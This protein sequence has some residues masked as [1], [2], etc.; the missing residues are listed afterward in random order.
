VPTPRLIPTFATAVNTWQC[1]E[2][3]HLNVQFYT[4]FGHEAS[5]HLLHRLGLGP[6]AR[7]AAGLSIRAC[8]D[9]IRYLR[10]F[11]V[12]E[13][14]EVRSAPVEVGE[15]TLVVYHEVL[16]A[17]DGT[18]AA[19][20][21]RRIESSR[22]WPDAFRARAEAA[23]VEMPPGA[24]PRSVGTPPL[25]PGV[26]EVAERIG[27]IMVGCTTV[28]PGECDEHDVF[29]PRH[30]FGRYSDAAPMLWNHF[31]FDHAG[32]QERGEGTVV[33]ETLHT[34]R[35]PL[36]AGNLLVVMSGLAGFTDKILKIAHYAFD[37][38]S[39]RLAAC[40]EAVA[41]KFDQRARKIMPFSVEDRARLSERKLHLFA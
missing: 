22:P 26:L 40:S 13:P 33:V 10:E 6:A 16:N 3:D 27:L 12:V 2:N 39:G 1:D 24:R 37:A 9:H 8:D 17:A 35:S 34:Y 28:K 20:I 4:E 14:V 30:Q 25:P 21:R 23:R 7:R 29:L 32:M 31:G 19:T 5:A 41:M 38:E 11:R 18:L 36:Q 15:R